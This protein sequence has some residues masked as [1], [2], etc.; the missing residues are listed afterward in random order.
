[1]ASSIGQASAA[2]A[3]SLLVLADHLSN[4]PEI[5]GDVFYCCLYIPT[6]LRSVACCPVLPMGPNAAMPRPSRHRLTVHFDE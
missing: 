6:L 5:A 4:A 3:H 1:L 2:T